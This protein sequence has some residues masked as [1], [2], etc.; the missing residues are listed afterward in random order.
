MT[1]YRAERRAANAMLTSASRAQVYQ[2]VSR[3][4]PYLARRRRARTRWL[5]PWLAF[6]VKVVVIGSF[7]FG[8]GFLTIVA[9]R[10]FSAG[11]QWLEL[12]PSDLTGGSLVP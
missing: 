4:S 6:T 9:A 8:C 7:A 5:S 2:S 1:A 10:Y 3:R 12:P 11:V